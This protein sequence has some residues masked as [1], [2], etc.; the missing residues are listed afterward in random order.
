MESQLPWAWMSP[1]AILNHEFTSQSDVWSYGV[2][3]YEVIFCLEMASYHSKQD[4]SIYSFLTK[5]VLIL[6]GVCRMGI[7]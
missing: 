3:L 5:E 6:M 2:F 4:Y 7:W 1:E